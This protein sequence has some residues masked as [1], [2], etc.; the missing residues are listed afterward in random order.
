MNIPVGLVD[1]G[2]KMGARFAPEM[3]GMDLTAI[4]VALKNGVQGRIVAMDDEQDDERVRDL[5]GVAGRIGS[6]G[7]DLGSCFA[8]PD[9]SQ[10]GPMSVQISTGEPANCRLVGSTLSV[11]NDFALVSFDARPSPLLYYSIVPCFTFSLCRLFPR[12]RIAP[13]NWSAPRCPERLLAAACVLLF[14]PGLFAASPAL[15]QKHARRSRD[16]H[17]APCGAC[18]T[19]R[20]GRPLLCASAGRVTRRGQRRRR[21]PALATGVYAGV[22]SRGGTTQALYVDKSITLRGGYKRA[23]WLLDPV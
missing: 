9:D 2:L 3:N 10:Q 20:C 8:H 5:C 19:L 7:K 21:D 23:D 4:Q 11:A 18:R 17:G 22:S 1:V 12:R 13:F 14:H 15:L 16:T 6:A